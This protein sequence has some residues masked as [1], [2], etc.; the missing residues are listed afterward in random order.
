MGIVRVG[1]V[2]DF[3]RNKHSHW[4][5]EAALFHAAAQIGH[6]VEP[7]WVPTSALAGAGATRQ[8]APFDA[9]WGAPGSPYD[10]VA[11][12]LD[13]IAHAR[14]HDIP[15][16]GTCGGFQYA[17]VEFSRNVLGVADAESAE[18]DPQGKNVVIT[19]VN[20]EIPA[21]GPRLHG[22]SIIH[23]T[24]GTLLEALCGPGDLS[25]EFF[26]SFETNRDFVPR[27][28]AAGL[29]VAARGQDGEMRAFELP[30]NRI[31]LATLFQPQLSSSHRRPHP[32][33]MGLLKA[34]AATRA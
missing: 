29:A 3:D 16:L 4:A 31:F 15:Y 21:R 32:I 7:E 8:L 12:M 17:L 20:C 34:A 22:A 2:G 11:G 25:G 9:L 18:N 1:I 10:S 14:T 19:A 13:A 30:A 5:T 24:P 6:T 23:P 26:C 27:W 33:V 28:V